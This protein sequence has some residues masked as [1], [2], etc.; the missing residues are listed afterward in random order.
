MA[1]IKALHRAHTVPGCL[2]MVASPTERQSG[3][4]LRKAEVLLAC[5][6]VRPRGDG[7]NPLSLLLPKGSRIVG[8]PGM[9]G[10]R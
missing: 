1:A 9:D 3:E 2:V 4:F 7:K 5:M 6:G 10:D 8:L